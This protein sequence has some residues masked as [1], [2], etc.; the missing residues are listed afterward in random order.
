MLLLMCDVRGIMH[1][2]VD[3]AERAEGLSMLH[4]IREWRE[5][6]TAAHPQ[7]MAPLYHTLALLHTAVGEKDKV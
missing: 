2:I 7:L 4:S 1:N 3:V 5:N 6:V